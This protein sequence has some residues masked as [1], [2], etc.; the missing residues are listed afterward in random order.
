M[1]EQSIFYTQMRYGGSAKPTV[2]VLR[3]LAAKSQ[4]PPHIFLVIVERPAFCCILALE[5]DDGY[6]WR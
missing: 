2:L 5:C 3:S 4:I 6:C 1:M